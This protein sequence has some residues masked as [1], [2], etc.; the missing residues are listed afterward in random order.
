MSR[1]NL[2]D[3]QF[4][5]NMLCR[6]SDTWISGSTLHPEAELIKNQPALPHPRPIRIR[7]S[8]ENYEAD[9]KA[10]AERS[11]SIGMGINR[12]YRKYMT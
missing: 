2:D 8:G 12:A 9:S 4:K 11:D 3:Y 6:D 7:A 1:K 10:V 5:S